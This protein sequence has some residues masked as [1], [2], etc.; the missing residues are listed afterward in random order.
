M[1]EE[2]RKEK[3]AL[4]YE[5][6]LMFGRYK[7]DLGEYAK[8]EA[9]RAKSLKALRKKE[10]KLS[11]LDLRPYRSKWQRKCIGWMSIFWKHTFARLGEDWVFLALLGILSS[12]LSFAMDYGIAICQ[13]ARIWLYRDLTE[14]PAQQYL[15]W[16]AFPLILMLF[17]AGFVHIVAAQAVGSGIPEMKTILRGVVLKE[18]LTFRTLVSKMVGLTASLGSGMPLGKEGP[19]VHVASIV[20][21]LLSKLVTSFKGIY[22]NESRTSEMLAAACA[23]GVACSF[24]API[25]G[26]LFSIEVTSVFFAVRNYWRGFFA[27]CCGAMVWRLLA[28]WFKDEET[29]TAL[30]K[31]NF[32][33]D[34]PFDPQE[35][36]AFAMIGVFCGFAGAFFVWFHRRIVEFNRKHKKLNTFLQKNRFIYP[37]IVTTVIATLTFPLGLGKFMASELTTHE[38]V[39]ELFSNTTWT[40]TNPPLDEAII[41]SHWSTT[42]S[43]I[44][45]N[46]VI[47]IVVTFLTTA[48]AATIPVPAGVFIPVFKMGAAFGRLVGECMAAWFPDGVRLGETVTKII[49]GGYAVVG[50]AALSGSVTHTV[51]TSVIVFELTGQMSHILPVIVA[52]LISN[53]IAQSLQPSIYDSIIKIKK[54]PYLPPI[55]TVSSVAHNVYVDEIMVRDVVHVWQGMTYR[56]IVNI[57]KMNKQFHSYP[58]VDSPES[59]I[60]LGSIQRV[61]LKKLLENQLGRERRLKEMARRQSIDD[62][63]NKLQFSD[64]PR[65]MSR[66]EIIPV[67]G[68][69]KLSTEISPT[70]SP[71]LSPKSP[72]KSIL[73]PS[74][75]TSPYSTITSQDFRLRQAFE[76]I[77]YKAKTLEDAYPDQTDVSA[78]STPSIQKRVQLPKE[79]VIDMSEEEQ[80]SWEE[81]QLNKPVDFGQCHIDPA[82]FQLVER[83]TLIKVHSL[84]S[85]LGLNHA[86]VTAIGRLVGIVALKEVRKAIENLHSGVFNRM[87]ESDD[88]G[89]E[90][91]ALSSELPSETHSETDEYI[92]ESRP[93]TRLYKSEVEDSH[94]V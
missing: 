31:T 50:A 2:S 83:T 91:E 78:P 93:L 51:S 44:Y 41:I 20:A 9:Q 17:S 89:P 58:F 6:T 69:D 16:L 34:F 28:V 40:G 74:P 47:Y 85:M 24:A 22:E 63:R 38:Q 27:A 59:M 4:G 43:N 29:I 67:S 64:Q 45:V 94:P 71:P 1:T 73:K 30:F 80:H 53:A 3:N 82:P 46:L 77:F 25:G 79:R 14:H 7:E 57:L 66:F 49:P 55:L 90:I 19:F 5:H 10:E 72:V 36:V 62:A 60:L 75:L 52:V 39:S 23:V 32:R 48:W 15:A 56:E 37:A 70:S 92:S 88:S 26:V 35:L 84:F 11:S 33:V 68:S 87:S 21:T 86:Y 61:E 8:A 12:L 42:Q 65:K 81:E 54:L 18:Y 76:T 13:K